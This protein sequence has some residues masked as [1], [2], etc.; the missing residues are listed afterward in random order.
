MQ[1]CDSD[2]TLPMMQWW[3][4]L[5]GHKIDMLVST[6]CAFVLHNVMIGKDLGN[7]I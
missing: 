1:P 6:H 4:H 5:L 3:S 7:V 2:T